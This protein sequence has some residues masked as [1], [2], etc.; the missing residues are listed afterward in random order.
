MIVIKQKNIFLKRTSAYKGVARE[1]RLYD[2][3][4]HSKNYNVHI[5]RY[6]NEIPTWYY[7]NV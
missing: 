4:K 2:A 3:I 1:K 5:K 6:C 7:K